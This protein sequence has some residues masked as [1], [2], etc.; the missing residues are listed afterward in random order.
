[1]HLKHQHSV[2]KMQD[3]YLNVN[4][5]V[6]KPGLHKEGYSKLTWRGHHPGFSPLE[7][8]MLTEEKEGSVHVNS[9][10]P[11][12]CAFVSQPQ[13]HLNRVWFGDHV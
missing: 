6:S 5:T 8:L 11:A 1:M 9:D 12:F 4:S 7:K 13:H 3:K 10:F 2:H